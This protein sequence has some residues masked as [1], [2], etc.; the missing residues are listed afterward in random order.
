MRIGD[1]FIQQWRMRVAARWVP[2]GSRVLDIG[3]HQGEFLEFLGGKIAP[4]A[5][6]DPL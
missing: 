3:C 4:S 6:L 1:Y 5:G 2:E